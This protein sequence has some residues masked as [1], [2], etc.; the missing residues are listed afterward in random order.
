MTCRMI[1]TSQT[2]AHD[3]PAYAAPARLALHREHRGGGSASR[4]SSGSWS[5]DSPLPGCPGCPPGLRSWR[6]SRSE[7]CRSRRRAF[8]R[9]FA[10]IGSFELGVPESELSI[11][12]RRSSSATRSSSRRRSSR[13]ASRSARAAANP[14]RRAASSAS[15]APITARSRATSSRCS[16]AAPGGS[17][18]SP[19]LAQPEL[20]VQTPSG[21]GVSRGQRAQHPVP[22]SES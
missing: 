8:L 21:H 3:D 22:R 14:S 6:R 20:E 12:S 17:N 16:P 4:R 19:K 11:R 13:S 10:P 7:D 9:S 1:L 15:L 2:C 5:R 18:T